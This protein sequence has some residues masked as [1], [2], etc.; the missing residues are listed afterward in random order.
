[1]DFRHP[2]KVVSATL[3]ADVLTLLARAEVEM[4]GREIHRLAGVGSQQG[5]RNAAERLVREGIVSRRAAGNAYLYRL[6]REHVAAS[7]IE[8]LASLPRLFIDR[9]RSAISGWDQ[10]PVFAVLF[11]SVAAG[12]STSASDVDLLVVRPRNVDPDKLPWTRQITMLQADST[13]WS[14]N[15]TKVLEFAEEELDEKNVDPL[16]HEALEAGIE[17][18]GSAQELLTCRQTRER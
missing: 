9:L 7:P 11:G 5:I 13:A 17:L 1:M 18:F 14:G 8:A 16:L 12:R 3:D 15:E 2:I 10:P 6:N 4:T